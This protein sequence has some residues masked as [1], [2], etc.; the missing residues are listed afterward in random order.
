MDVGYANL[1]RHCTQGVEFVFYNAK[2]MN[3]ISQCNAKHY[4]LCHVGMTSQ[5]CSTAWTQDRLHFV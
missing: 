5:I 2:H 4:T 3:P 1:I